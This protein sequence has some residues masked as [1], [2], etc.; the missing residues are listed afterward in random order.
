[1]KLMYILCAVPVLLLLTEESFLSNTRFINTSN[2]KNTEA[3]V[4]WQDKR[5]SC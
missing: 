5:R 4:I 3:V 2:I 1:M